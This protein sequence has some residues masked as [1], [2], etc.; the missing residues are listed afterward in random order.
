MAILKTKILFET[1]A[2]IEKI[3]LK[4]YLSLF[5]AKKV[6]HIQN[7]FE[8]MCKFTKRNR[9]KPERTFDH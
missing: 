5:I 2:C 3:S 4:K 7:C 8:S 1:L 9:K 6:S